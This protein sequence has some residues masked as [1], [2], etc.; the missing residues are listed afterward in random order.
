MTHS[1]NSVLQANTHNQS[2]AAAI[3]GSAEIIQLGQHHPAQSKAYVGHPS[4]IFSSIEQM[5]EQPLTDL[6]W[7]GSVVEST[8]F[9]QSKTTDLQS[10]KQFVMTSLETLQGL[11]SAMR[12][13][14][15]LN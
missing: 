7:L 12:N 9:A 2:E 14:S 6:V 4:H 3:A 13:D 8:P 10:A 1:C 15:A 11:Y 5:H